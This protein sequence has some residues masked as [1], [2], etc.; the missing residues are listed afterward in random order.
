[1]TEDLALQ[2]RKQ[3]ETSEGSGEFR[4]VIA[5][6]KWKP[7]ETAV[8]ICDMW[9][10]H[11]CKGATRRVAEM[12]PRMNQF[13][14]V[15]R[16]KGALI[17]H[18]PSGTIDHYKDHPARKRA[19]NAPKAADLPEGIA[20]GC[21]W[22]DEKEEKA[23]LPVDASDG[24]CDCEPQCKHPPYPWTQQIDT[25]DIRDEDA[26]TDSGVEAWN[27]FAERGIR[28]VILVGV[29]TNMCVVGR[30]FGLRNMARFGKNVVLVRDLTD[31]MYNPRKAPFVS[32][33]TGTDLIVE[34]IEKYICPTIASTALLGGTPF[35]LP[36][37]AR[38][39]VVF[40]ISEDEYRAAETLPRL[41][42]D[43]E[44]ECGL[45]CEALHGN[46]KDGNDVPGMEALADADL[47]VLFLRRRALPADQ[48][49][50]IRDYLNRG[51]PLVAL[52]TTSHGFDVG[53]RAPEGREE[54]RNFDSEA[55]GGHYGGHH[56]GSLVAQVSLATGAGDHPILK[57][58]PAGGIKSGGSL[59]RSNPL[60][61]TA[62]ALLMGTVEGH[63]SE[64]ALWTNAY[65][66][67]RVVYTSLG[68]PK[69]FENEAFRALLIRAFFWAMDRP[70][71]GESADA[72][73]AG[74]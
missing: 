63:P 39:R 61:P 55:L 65:Q 70:A 15:A 2:V 17:V 37:D 57:G 66:T 72:K 44:L 69:D 4:P 23:G 20:G 46:P 42:R 60:T 71:P 32:H 3:V 56:D 30:P 33:F 9:N 62:Q 11:W 38:P 45:A 51:K 5:E 13:V 53:G 22:I 64:P 29:H 19:Q 43:L 10:E 40:V 36:N 16:E 67:S 7:S 6:E 8:I 31:T 50:R 24:G 18:A 12:A 73:S 54:W 34:H 47:A 35:H 27:L 41:A 25:I 52:R 48:L 58:F 74:P 59:Y 28:N 14:G 26:I 49:R 68:H 21:G 1:M